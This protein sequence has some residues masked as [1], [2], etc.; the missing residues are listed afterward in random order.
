MTTL[1]I[2]WIYNISDVIFKIAKNK[3]EKNL[4]LKRNN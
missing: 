3:T 1:R 4:E 2:F